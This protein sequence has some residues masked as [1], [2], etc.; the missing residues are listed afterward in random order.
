MILAVQFTYKKLDF[1]GQQVEE[2]EL[3]F[4]KK[5]YDSLRQHV[6]RNKSR[7]MN[8]YFPI[9]SKWNTMGIRLHVNYM[10]INTMSETIKEK[11]H[12]C[13]SNTM[14]SYNQNM[15]KLIMMTS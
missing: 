3:L 12:L 13:F 2:Y 5:E 4:S 9:V 1:I 7:N 15:N 10:F 6:T 11:N 8:F 14:S